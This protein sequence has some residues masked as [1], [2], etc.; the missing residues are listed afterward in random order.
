M[1]VPVSTPPTPGQDTPVVGL[2]ANPVASKDIRRLVGL[3]RVVDAEEKANLIARLLAGMTAGPALRVVALDDSGGLVR[4]ALRLARGS[5]PPLEYLPVQAETTEN[6]TRQAASLMEE[7]GVVAV[8]TVG[9]DGTIRS[10]VEGWP[11]ARLVPVSSGTNNAVAIAEEPTA[12]GY[13][14]ALAARGQV[15]NAFAQLSALSVDTGRPETSTAVVDVVGVRTHWTG[16]R[17]LWEPQ[18]L[19]EAVITNARPTAVGI[20]SVAT[21]L[22]PMREGHARHVR[23]GPGTRVRALLGPGLVADVSVAEYR[24]VPE[25]TR[26][27]LDPTTRVVALDG[28]RRLVRAAAHVQVVAG[29]QLLSVSRVLADRGTPD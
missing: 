25:G 4:R 10:A 14:V 29:P 1:D 24:D 27:D 3:A 16:A 5:A 9:G 28:E 11:S 13:A 15:E 17:A 18:D 12:I 6:D 7:M 19:V 8:V 26:I 21:G 20:A 23:F 2:I 22:G